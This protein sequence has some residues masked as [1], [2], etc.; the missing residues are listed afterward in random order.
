MSAARL[1]VSSG[2]TRCA[3][4][5]ADCA[6]RRHLQSMSGLWMQQLRDAAGV[7]AGHVARLFRKPSCRL[8]NRAMAPRNGYAPPA[9]TLRK[10]NLERIAR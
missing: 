4:A 5:Q 6:M 1:G 2:I 9:C 8:Q 3:A 7:S 10:V